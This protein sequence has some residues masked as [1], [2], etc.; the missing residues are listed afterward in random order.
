MNNNLSHSLNK[1]KKTTIQ[2]DV[3]HPGMGQ[4]HACGSVKF[5]NGILL[6]TGSPTAIHI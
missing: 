2:Y 4:A 6:I 3:A 5:I 1:H